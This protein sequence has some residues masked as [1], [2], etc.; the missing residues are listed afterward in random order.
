VHTFV[1]L[2]LR[3]V[4]YYVR[5]AFGKQKIVKGLF[6]LLR[7]ARVACIQQTQD[8]GHTEAGF[9]QLFPFTNVH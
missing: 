6:C 2:L 8:E 5:V 9:A 7:F 1:R 3:A 4:S